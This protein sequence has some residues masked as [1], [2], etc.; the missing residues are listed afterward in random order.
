MSRSRI[1][2]KPS[3]SATEP[4]AVSPDRSFSNQV[5]EI[6]NRLDGIREGLDLYFDGVSA[7]TD[8]GSASWSWFLI[9]L[10]DN[11]GEAIAEQ[12]ELSERLREITK[13]RAA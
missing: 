2:P 8:E 9:M 10:Q 7:Q 4:S 12:R 5:E 11:L 13:G 1:A 6:A 3:T